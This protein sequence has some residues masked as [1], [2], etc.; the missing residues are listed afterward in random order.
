MWEKNFVCSVSL[1]C[2]TK[3]VRSEAGTKEG[4]DILFD[5]V[6]AVKAQK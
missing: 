3:R 4:K 5:I 2:E 6:G 1:N